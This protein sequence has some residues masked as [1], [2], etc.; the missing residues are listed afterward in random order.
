[1]GASTIPGAGRGCFATRALRPGDLVGEYRGEVMSRAVAEGRRRASAYLID[2]DPTTVVDGQGSSS[3][4]TRANHS[5]EPNANAE[6]VKRR[7]RVEGNS[8]VADA[9]FARALRHIQEDE[10]VLIDYGRNYPTNFREEG[11]EEEEEEER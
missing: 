10:E 7:V 11:A 5:E 9:I 6:F 8:R 2:L 3:A 1:M 4:V